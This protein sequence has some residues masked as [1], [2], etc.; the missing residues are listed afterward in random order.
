[1]DKTLNKQVLLF[2]KISYWEAW[3]YVILLFVAMPLKYLMDLPIAVRIVGMLHGLLF[4]AYAFQ[5]L[6]L[7]ILKALGF[8]K[9]VVYFIASLLPFAAFW[10]EKDVKKPA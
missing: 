10:V 7:L 6:Y 5:L 9:A 2:A 1:M 4:V 8:P 3:S